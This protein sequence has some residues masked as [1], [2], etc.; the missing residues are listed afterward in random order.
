MKLIKIV[1]SGGPGGGKSSCMP[2]LRRHFEGLGY[3][4]I[5]VP[6]TASELI[7]SGISAVT[8][9]SQTDFQTCLMRLQLEKEKILTDYAARLGK[10]TVLMLLDRGVQDNR[11]YLTEEEFSAVL[12]RNGISA[13]RALLGYDA[14]FLMRSPAVDKPSYYTTENNSARTETVSEAAAADGKTAQAWSAHPELRIIPN[15]GDFEAKTAAL[16]DGI[17]KFLGI[18]V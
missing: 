3:G 15:S 2:A 18:G 10:E 9:G 8:L 13:E 1:I 12:D 16:I 5:T 6:E 4:V 17:S 14:V 7:K 11:A